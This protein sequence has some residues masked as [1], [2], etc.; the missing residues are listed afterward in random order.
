MSRSNYFAQIIGLNVI[1]VI[2]ATLAGL[3]L[4]YKNQTV[5]V[6]AGLGVVAFFMAINRSFKTAMREESERDAALI[7]NIKRKYIFNDVKLLETSP[8]DRSEYGLGVLVFDGSE[9]QELYVRT[10]DKNHEPFLF[11][12]SHGEKTLIESWYERAAS[13]S[14]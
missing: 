12:V 8:A 7:N 14:V 2:F 3:G 4:I 10:S 9:H 6:I 11:A 13:V 1:I 5:L